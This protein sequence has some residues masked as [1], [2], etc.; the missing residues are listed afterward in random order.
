MFIDSNN[1]IHL[2]LRT[3]VIGCP[4]FREVKDSENGTLFRLQGFTKKA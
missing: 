4:L 2:R 1:K 3:Y